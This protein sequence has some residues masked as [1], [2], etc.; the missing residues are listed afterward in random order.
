[1]AN[2]SQPNRYRGR[3]KG[4]KNKRRPVLR[5]PQVRDDVKPERR[6]GKAD[7]RVV[8]QLV[9]LDNRYTA[10][11]LYVE[12][13][14]SQVDIAAAL[15]VGQQRVSQ[16]LTDVTKEKRDN[17]ASLSDIA[18]VAAL[19]RVQLMRRNYSEAALGGDIKS[20]ELL[21]KWEERGDKING[22]YVNRTE[23]LTKRTAEAES[24][25]DI[26]LLNAEQLGWLEIILTVG[27]R[28]PKSEVP[29][30]VDET[31]VADQ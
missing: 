14:Y 17:I 26:A 18:R 1:M 21:L 8:R 12:E 15:G 9:A 30:L 29:V 5:A 11:K 24:E 22:L 4:S 6:T 20:A 28:K 25:I 7:G 10:W 27:A 19:E 3:K 31:V 23:D 16:Y 2:D 13:G